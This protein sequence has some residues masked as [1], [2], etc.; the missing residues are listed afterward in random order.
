M[1]NNLDDDGAIKIVVP[2]G[3]LFSSQD[4]N[5]IKQFVDNELISSIIGLPGGLF[6]T[7]GIQT[8]LLIIN[9]KPTNEGIYYLNTRNAK[10]EKRLKRKISIQDIDKY[11][12]LLSNKEEQELISTIATIE[13]IQEND[14]NLSINRYVDSEKLEEIDIEQTIANIKA[15]KKE[16][17]QVDE[18]LNTKLGGLLK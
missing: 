17:K 12:R 8:T 16:L 5:I 4:K 2:N 10:I 3:V 13:D 9:K 6:D 14:Y 7:T 15:I 1:F 11:T 18:E